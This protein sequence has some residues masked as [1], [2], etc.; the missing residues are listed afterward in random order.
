MI[1]LFL[2]L[3]IIW[4]II[5]VNESGLLG[6]TQQLSELGRESKLSPVNQNEHQQS[7]NPFAYIEIPAVPFNSPVKPGEHEVKKE[8]SHSHDTTEV[9]VKSIFYL[10]NTS[11]KFVL[12]YQTRSKK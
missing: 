5:S 1:F 6:V 4:V 3:D 12:Y 9:Y 11:C 7:F 8:R 10:Q 2:H